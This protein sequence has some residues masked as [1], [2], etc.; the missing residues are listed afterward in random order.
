[1]SHKED[2]S[3]PAP[4]RDAKARSAAGAKGRRV[5]RTL[6]KGTLFAAGL[7]ASQLTV[8]EID[9]RFEIF[10]KTLVDRL[11]APITRHHE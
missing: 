8:A 4:K 6:A 10:S 11:Q 2:P 3:K 5:V 9:P 7:A 1:M